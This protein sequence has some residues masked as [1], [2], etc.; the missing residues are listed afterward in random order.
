MKRESCKS[1]PSGARG[2]TLLEMIITLAILSIVVAGAIPIARN[3]AQ[4]QREVELRRA[5]REIRQAIDAYKAACDAGKIS[6]LERNSADDLCYPPK[7]EI[8]VEG[9]MPKGTG[10]DKL[11]FLRRLPEDPM[12]GSTKWGTRSI[13]DEKGS[14]GGSQNVWDVFTR[15]DATAL[16]GSKY[17]DW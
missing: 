6:D 2:F 15:S 7:L 9:V 13:Q 12:T 17:K 1:E 11:K 4:R 14:S 3:A 16:D 10:T 5:L 8:L